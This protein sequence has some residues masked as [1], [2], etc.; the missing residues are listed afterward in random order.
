L[1]AGGPDEAEDVEAL[2]WR[3]YEKAVEKRGGGS[4][5]PTV[6]FFYASA[7]VADR[8]TPMII[9]VQGLIAA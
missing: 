7:V 9:V 8:Q 2:C 4:T 5:Q 3:C 6:L 1:E